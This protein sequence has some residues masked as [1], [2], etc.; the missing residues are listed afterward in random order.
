MVQLVVFF[1]AFGFLV[2]NGTGVIGAFLL[3]LGIS[4]VASLIFIAIIA[5]IDR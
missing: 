1:V 4:F 3:A 2:A 5:A